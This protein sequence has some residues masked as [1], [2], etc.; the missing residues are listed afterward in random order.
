[1]VR[2]CFSI[3]ILIICFFGANA[4][5]NGVDY[6]S[7]VVLVKFTPEAYAQLAAL[8]AVFSE[9]KQA[10]YL[11][12]LPK[13]QLLP[14]HSNK[15]RS[16]QQLHL[17]FEY[18]L[19]V[20]T[21]PLKISKW[22]SEASFVQYAQP[23]YIAHTDAT[24]NDPSITSQWYL[25]TISAFS[26]WDISTGT[27]WP[28]IGVVD[29]GTD[30]THPDHVGK[31]SFN[32]NDPVNG[33][34]D[35][36]DGYTDNYYG[37]NFTNNSNDVSLTQNDHGLHMAG[38]AAAAT[39]NGIGVAGVG[40][41]SKYLPIKVGN[42][43]EITYGYEGI[44][45]AADHNCFVINCSWG[46]YY[47]GQFERD[48]FDY[49][50]QTQNSLVVAAA[51]NQNINLPYF[52]AAFEAAL[53]VAGTNQADY[54]GSFS[55]YNYE[56][57]IAAPGDQIFGTTFNGGYNT[58]TG[59]SP[60]TAIVSGAAAIAV[61]LNP[62][63]SPQQ[64]KALLTESVDDIYQFASNAP[65][66]YQLGN[67]RLNM[68]KAFLGA[69]MALRLENLAFTDHN[70]NIFV[71]GDTVFV[72]G[73]VSHYFSQTAL[74]PQLSVLFSSA[75]LQPIVNSLNLPALSWN[76]YD[77]S[78]TP[79]QLLVT[80]AAAVNEEV[81]LVFSLTEGAYEHKRAASVSL[82]ADYVNLQ[83]NNLALSVGSRGLVGY[84]QVNGNQGIG[85]RYKGGESLMYEGGILIGAKVSGNY[86]VADCIRSQT[87]LNDLDFASQFNAHFVG[88][89]ANETERVAGIY[90]DSLASVLNKVGV[91][92]QQQCFGYADAGHENYIVVDLQIENASQ[93][94]LDSV[95]V[96]WLMDYD[97]GQYD[98]NKTKRD[99]QRFLFYTQQLDTTSVAAGVQL[100]T[101]TA[102]T[103][104]GIDNVSG[105][106]GGVNIYNGFLAI[107]KWKVLSKN[108]FD[109]GNAA[110]GEDVV[111]VISAGP[112]QLQADSSVHVA[113]AVVVGETVD[114]LKQAAD[115]AYFRFNNKLPTQV[116]RVQNESLEFRFYPNPAHDAISL[117]NVDQ[118][119]SVQLLDVQGKHLQDFSGKD[120]SQTI[121]LSG[122][123]PG[124]YFLRAVSKQGDVSTNKLVKIQ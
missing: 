7:N 1:M 61:V 72:T 50:T 23:R 37:W 92:V 112:F 45:Y 121:S 89:L 75:G 33:V 113:F 42:S 120:L 78:A 84:N 87:N 40:Y 123:K 10:S 105:G 9:E 16:P 34:D 86:P 91:R 114:S 32:Q 85:L 106:A 13:R 3:V 60:A 62:F 73:I 68:H 100:L 119:I 82:N 30:L 63:Y 54:K 22:L 108:R 55:N 17:L 81:E 18:E 109:A 11:Q 25:Q 115:S 66:L 117:K 43:T 71:A 46:G 58:K 122:L 93:N 5:V 2:I 67:G 99:A 52:P 94:Q 35:D 102:A 49:A 19:P 79:L 44:V 14:A 90:S 98:E 12:N 83:P 95:F 74:N 107:D 69:N 53:S 103:M 80:N 118:L 20:N 47:Y 88:P 70:D 51:G 76:S 28:I 57:D 24:P 36:N 104:Y 26:A 77:F 15:T 6:V 97:L 56:I 21:N 64:I 59:T 111:Q 4:Q 96:G 65:Y 29:A 41:A 38:V 48:M 101:S 39:N 27:N 31:V 116:E 124:I 8:E 110:T